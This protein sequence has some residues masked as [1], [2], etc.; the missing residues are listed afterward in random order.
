[1]TNT[2]LLALL[3]FGASLPALAWLGPRISLGIQQIVYNLTGSVDYTV[4]VYFLLMLPGIVVHELAHW[5]TAW[6]LGLRPGKLTVWPKRHRQDVVGLGSVTARSG[7]PLLDSMVGMAPLFV[8]T[9]LVA[10]MAA[11]GWAIRPW[12]RILS[13]RA[14]AAGSQPFQAAFRRPDTGVVGMGHLRDCQ[15]HDAQRTR[16]RTAQTALCLYRADDIAL[17]AHRPAPATGGQPAGGNG[18]APDA[19]EQQPVYQSHC[20]WMLACWPCSFWVRPSPHTAAAH[21]RLLQRILLASRPSLV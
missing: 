13:A 9:L 5:V 3:L 4:V 12:R 2:T 6:M 19:T 18:H 21:K 15:W 1:M 10:F 16:S 17:P 7:G 8:G 20:C 14:Q 11:R